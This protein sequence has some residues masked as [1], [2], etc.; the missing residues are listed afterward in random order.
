MIIQVFCNL[1][2]SMSQYDVLLSPFIAL[3][4]SPMPL[5]I[6]M[7]IDIYLYISIYQYVKFNILRVRYIFFYF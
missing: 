7:Y 2:I 4:K 3:A 6:N 1:S 5:N